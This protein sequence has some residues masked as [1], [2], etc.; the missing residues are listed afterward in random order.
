MSPRLL[1]ALLLAAGCGAAPLPVTE[2]ATVT[3]PPA[4]VA[5]RPGTH[6]TWMDGA[7]KSPLLAL[8]EGETSLSRAAL[9][10]G[11]RASSLYATR[12]ADNLA[13]PVPESAA[14]AVSDTFGARHL[15]VQYQGSTRAG[16]TVTRTKAEALDRA[17]EAMRKAQA[18][19]P[20]EEVVREYSDEPGAAQRGGNLGSFRRGQMVPTFQ[21]AVEALRVGEVSGVIETPFGYHVILRTQ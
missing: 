21:A 18:G 10:A 7:G 13:H 6:C 4:G 11:T 1:A 16:A 19:A 20:F 12:C 5:A 2:P 3:V 9:A 17:R 14:A 15:L 8:I